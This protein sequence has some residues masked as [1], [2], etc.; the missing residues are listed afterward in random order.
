MVFS[1]LRKLYIFRKNIIGKFRKVRLFGFG[2]FLFKFSVAYS[3]LYLEMIVKHV[4]N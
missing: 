2:Y 1:M 4:A 3:M